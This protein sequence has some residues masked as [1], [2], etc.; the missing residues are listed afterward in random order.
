MYYRRNLSHRDI[1]DL[2]AERGVHVSYGVA[3][4]ELSPGTILD[5]SQYA[6]MTRVRER[7][8]RR[9][10]LPRQAQHFVSTDFNNCLIGN[11][12]AHLKNFAL[13]RL[14]HFFVKPLERSLPSDVLRHAFSSDDDFRF[15]SL[16]ISDGYEKQLY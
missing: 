13:R 12:D 11:G 4:R 2:L 10:K 8:M 5:T 7:E 6:N 1:E 9:L 15:Q 16:D 3:H 14:H